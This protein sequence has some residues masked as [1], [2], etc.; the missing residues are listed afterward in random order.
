MEGLR[1]MKDLYCFYANAFLKHKIII[2]PS[3]E[4]DLTNACNQ[5]CFYCNY[6]EKRGKTK[7]IA[8]T[9]DYY[10]LIDRLK[11]WGTRSENEIGKV[12]TLTFV[13]GGEPT[14]FPRYHEI[15]EE[16]IEKGFIVSLI[17]NGAKLGCLPDDIAKRMAWI[18]IDFDA[19]TEQ[20]YNEIRG[21]KGKNYFS[22][23]SDEARRLSEAGAKI[24]YKVLLVDNNNNADAIQDIFRNAA[25]VK[26]RMIYFRLAVIKGKST[27]IDETTLRFSDFSRQY[28]VPYRLNLTRT[29]KR[30]YS[31]CYAMHLL[32]VFTATGKVCLCC[33]NRE[34]NEYNLCSWIDEDFEQL[35]GTEVHRQ[36]VERINVKN[37]VMC[38]SNIH[39]I[40]IQNIIN[41]EDSLEQLF[42]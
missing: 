7:D 11:R 13:G 4:I 17:T 22:N 19:G 36:M 39:N 38:R 6:S 33:E 40:S 2:P 10:K 24:D 1:H 35:W 9:S 37:C 3:A 32:P 18:G 20:L 29:L 25:Y 8:K 41:N 34:V 27:V 28:G 31:Y 23:V 26:A 21:T 15:L 12:N 16:G 42:F 30:N 5:N 14:L